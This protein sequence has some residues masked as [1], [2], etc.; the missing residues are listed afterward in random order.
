MPKNNIRSWE[1][2]LASK[3]PRRKELLSRLGVPF[4]IL[5]SDIEEKSSIQDPKGYALDI[6]EQKNHAITSQLSIDRKL[7][8]SCDTVVASGDRIFGKPESKSEARQ[9]LE[10]LSGKTHSVHTAL[11]AVSAGFSYRHVE[12]T[13]VSF[14]EIQPSQLDKYI[15]TGDSLDKA[16]GY[17]IQGEALSFIK[18]I[19][20]CYANVVGFPLAHFCAM[21]DKEFRARQGWDKPWQNYF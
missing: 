7:I 10:A 6:A 12:T 11:V 18:G 15:E 13:E 8:V 17:G 21:M 19:N 9:F 14:I 5:V 16:G 3:S 4:T 20:G 2:I 1:I